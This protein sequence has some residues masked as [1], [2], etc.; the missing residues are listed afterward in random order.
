[1]SKRKQ[2]GRNFFLKLKSKKE[3]LKQLQHEAEVK[4]YEAVEAKKTADALAKQLRTKLQREDDIEETLECEL[5][6]ENKYHP[7]LFP[8][9]N[10]AAT[11]SMPEFC[12]Y[13]M[14]VPQSWWSDIDCAGMVRVV[15]KKPGQESE[16]LGV[17]FSEAALFQA[18]HITTEKSIKWLSESIARQL[19]DIFMHHNGRQNYYMPIKNYP[20][21]NPI[22][23][24]PKRVA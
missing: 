19:W 5:Q 17:G 4:V 11:Y 20:P 8:D 10:I 12:Q 15:C 2:P 7:L 16:E 9:F 22:Y 14:T 13:R 6:N 23:R 18:S 1:M 3:Q 24:R 21:K